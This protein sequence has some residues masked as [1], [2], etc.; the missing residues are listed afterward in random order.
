M[1]YIVFE[2]EFDN[3]EKDLSENDINTVISE[4]NEECGTECDTIH[5]YT[6]ASI[7]TFFDIHFTELYD[8]D[9]IIEETHIYL[10]KLAEKHPKVGLTCYYS[11]SC[12]DDYE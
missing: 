1:A 6:D 10:N 4:I 12:F 2:I 9:K 5:C 3:S 8:N 7:E 11:E